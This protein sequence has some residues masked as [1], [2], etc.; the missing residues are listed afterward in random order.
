MGFFKKL[1]SFASA[2]WDKIKGGVSP[3]QEAVDFGE[4][5]GF[6]ISPISAYGELSNIRRQDDLAPFVASILP[7]DYIPE[8]YYSES[9]IPW[10]RPFAYN[11]EFYGVNID[12][13]EIEQTERVLTYSRPVPVETILSDAEQR[14][15]A[16]GDYPQIDIMEMGVTAAMTRPDEG[17]F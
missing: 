10:N 14:F 12:T 17:R 9:N 3:V 8:E 13:G 15:G 5:F 4:Q 11:V 6:D 7:E 16:D 2:V 1:G